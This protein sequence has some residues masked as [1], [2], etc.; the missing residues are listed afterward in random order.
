[1]NAH[2]SVS[3]KTDVD[4]LH[5]PSSQSFSSSFLIHHECFAIKVRLQTHRQRVCTVATITVEISNRNVVVAYSGRASQRGGG[6]SHMLLS[7]PNEM[8]GTGTRELLDFDRMI[9]S[10]DLFRPINKSHKIV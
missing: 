10:L 8:I 4:A 2:A 3:I 7:D 5:S 6:G 9:N 1:M